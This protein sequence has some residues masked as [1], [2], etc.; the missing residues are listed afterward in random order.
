MLFARV[1]VVLVVSGNNVS[2]ALIYI[3]QLYKFLAFNFKKIVHLDE[4]I[5]IIN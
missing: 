1:F 4:L 2:V 5:K 3:F